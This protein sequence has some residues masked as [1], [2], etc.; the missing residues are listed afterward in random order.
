MK[1]FIAQNWNNVAEP[2]L[3][4]H[5]EG[6]YIVKFYSISDLKA[7]LYGGP[8]SINSRPMILKQWTLDFDLSSDLL[9]EIPL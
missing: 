7:I 2:N 1:C 4:Q 5:E 9:T 6:Y 8:Y 3:Y